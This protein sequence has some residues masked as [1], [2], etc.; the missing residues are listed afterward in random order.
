[1]EIL[2]PALS[3]LERSQEGLI[4]RHVWKNQE[5]V[6]PIPSGVNVKGV[7]L[8]VNAEGLFFFLNSDSYSSDEWFLWNALTLTKR[9]VS[10]RIYFFESYSE[11]AFFKCFSHLYDPF[12]RKIK[13]LAENPKVTAKCVKGRQF[14][15]NLLI[16]N[17]DFEAYSKEITI[18]KVFSENEI[19]YY[20]LTPEMA[21]SD[22]LRK[23]TKI[24][25]SIDE[26][27]EIFSNIW[28]AGYEIE[29]S[30]KV[31]FDKGKP[32]MKIRVRNLLIEKNMISLSAEVSFIYGKNSPNKILLR[33]L[34]LED[35]CRD[36]LL[37]KGLKLDDTLMYGN[38]DVA[39][40]VLKSL[41]KL[42][43]E[44][45]ASTG[46]ELQIRSAVKNINSVI[47]GTSYKCLLNS[48]TVKIFPNMPKEEFELLAQSLHNENL[49]ERSWI[50]INGKIM[51]IMFPSLGYLKN[52]LAYYGFSVNFKE[53]C[54]EAKNVNVIG[55]ISLSRF[56]EAYPW[57]TKSGFEKLDK[58]R[59]KIQSFS[60]LDF[61]EQYSFLRP[62]QKF[63]VSWICHLFQH[64]LGALL[65]DE[66]GLGKTVQTLVALDYLINRGLLKKAL[67]ICPTSVVYNWEREAQKFTPNLRGV[68]FHGP[69]RK[70]A[71]DNIMNS[72]VI[73]TSYN[74]VRLDNHI[75]KDISFDAIIMDEAQFLKNADSLTTKAVK[76]LKSS[77]KLALTGTPVENRPLE[78]WSIFDAILS[79]SLGTRS[80][81]EKRI[82]KNQNDE[83][84]KRL[85][86]SI[87]PF[88]LRR[89]K[90]ENLEALPPKIETVE[91]CEMT[92]Q[93]REIYELY[94]SRGIEMAKSWVGKGVSYTHIFALITKLR[95]ICDHPR[96]VESDNNE[97]LKSG[98]L[99]RLLEVLGEILSNDR[100][101][102]VFCQFLPMVDIIS[103]ELCQRNIP[104]FVLTGKT[105]NRL[106][107]IDKFNG[108]HE[109]SVLVISL[110]AGG[111][112]VNLTGASDVILY[113][114]WWNPQVENQA[115]DRLHRIGQKNTVF[116]YRF[117]TVDSIESKMEQIKEKKLNLFN[118][119]LSGARNKLDFNLLVSLLY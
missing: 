95:Q 22:I 116:V 50:S 33:D 61:G 23:G 98:K 108:C 46:V 3:S 96:I 59:E 40:Q 112:G 53:R 80:F 115:I 89:R 64:K 42:N 84:L 105:S 4:V 67:V 44:F 86:N 48:S 15:L 71:L 29:T 13:V 90:N 25:F 60:E 101:A 28:H 1:M 103:Q 10:N 69:K 63:G 20:L 62:Y 49:L 100:K 76:D 34:K 111:I 52:F 75:F 102:V 43:D 106:E 11:L 55:L 8:E 12:G 16:N 37:S 92:E 38:N 27:T 41:S 47:S 77:F 70:D 14:E 119:I 24:I 18:F 83:T 78:L 118:Q 114:P 117:I 107:V 104:K 82:E 45:E 110:K 97:S 65:A 5:K 9:P 74:L 93:Q 56:L 7:I 66:M 79:K 54:F 2:K 21:V 6:V 39:F 72:D 17:K 94:R 31:K 32:I 68:V 81:F 58:Q 57:I 30:P 99:T 113:D 87:S 73:F 85:A 26:A 19:F 109:P 91:Y 36:F 51:D 88:I 35:K